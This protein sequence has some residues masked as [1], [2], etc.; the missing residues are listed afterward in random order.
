M[1][2]ILQLGLQLLK[3]LQRTLQVF[4]DII[5]QHIGCRQIVQIGKRLVLDPENVEAG[6]VPCQNVRNVEFAPAAIWIILAPRFGALIAVFRMIT[7]N[8]ILQVGILH[9]I[10]LQ[11][12]M[13]IGAEI[14]DPHCLRLRFGAGWTLVEKDHVGLDAGFIEDT[15]RQTQDRV[16]VAVGKE[17]LADDFTRATL[18]QHIV[19]H[20][21][22]GLAR[23]LQD[24]VDV[25]HKIELLVATGGPEI[26]TVIDEIL[27]FLFAILIGE[28]EG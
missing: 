2:L 20:D 4:D 23:C 3:A 5:G 15:S 22:S 9:R 16:Q 18:E 19:R 26:L 13:D 12:E 10:L 14:I 8:E 27:F 7:G 21:H 28:G 17:L 6:L 1:T 25:L 11:R 24:R